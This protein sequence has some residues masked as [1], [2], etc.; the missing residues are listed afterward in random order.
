MGNDGRWGYKHAQD[1]VLVGPPQVDLTKLNTFFELINS[2]DKT[3]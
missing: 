1:A 3:Y 2:T